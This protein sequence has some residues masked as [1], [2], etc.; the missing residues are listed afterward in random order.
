[1]ELFQVPHTAKVNRVIPKNAFDEYT[2]TKQK[3]L[4]ADLIARITWLY[5]LSPETV[6]LEAKEIKEIQIFKIELKQKEDIRIILD[7]IEKS[8]PYTI[9]SIVEFEEKVYFSTSIKHPHPLNENNAVLDWTFTSAWLSPSTAEYQLN[10][11]KNLD[12][13]YQDFCVQLTHKPEL[14]HKKLSD[15]VQFMREK[16][17]LESE[18]NQLKKSIKTAKLFKNKVELNMLLKQRTN[19]LKRLNIS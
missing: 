6:N 2:N 7:I 17:S 16:E 15:I 1:M 9:I 10:L 4:F 14:A 5:K 11:K 19:E 18:I 12:A 3:K 13:V 8:I